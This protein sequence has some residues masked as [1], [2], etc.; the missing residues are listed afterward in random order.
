MTLKTKAPLQILIPKH[1]LLDVPETPQIQQVQSANFISLASSCPLPH[2]SE[3]NM[4]PLSYFPP[5]WTGTSRPC[6]RRCHSDQALE[7]LL[8]FSSMPLILLLLPKVKP[9]FLPKILKI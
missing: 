5:L 3:G 9:H 2:I 7:T 6:P 8:M 4:F 1:L